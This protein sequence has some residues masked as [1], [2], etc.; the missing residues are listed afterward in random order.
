MELDLAKP[1]KQGFWIGDDDDRVFVVVLYERLPTFCY[2]CG[3]VGHGSNNCNRRSSGGSGHPSP[4]RSTDLASRQRQEVRDEPEARSEG[5]EAE[6][7]PRQSDILEETENL[8]ELSKTDYGPWMLVER[9]RGRGG[10]RGSAGGAGRPGS[11]AAHATSRDPGSRPSNVSIPNVSNVRSSAAGTTRGG[12]SGRGRGGAVS[13]RAQGS[14]AVIAEMTHSSDKAHIPMS[15]DSNLALVTPLKLGPEKSIP[16]DG[17]IASASKEAMAHVSSLSS[18]EPETPVMLPCP[19]SLELDKGKKVVVDK[20]LIPLT[21]PPI[22]RT[23]ADTGDG[24][25]PGG[26]PEAHQ[27]MVDKVSSVLMSSSGGSSGSE[28]DMSDSDDVEGG[29][30][31]GEELME[32]DDLMTLVQYQSSHR[33]EHLSRKIA[34]PQMTSHKKGR[35]GMEGEVS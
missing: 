34:Q 25:V 29:V 7:D 31:E 8:D 35:V 1:L 3:L 4:P 5:M 18:K 23:S 16:S 6:M 20:S 30:S 27:M 11:R 2:K 14:R 22:L 26:L 10:G 17:R 19:I 13:G 15:P 21:N 28:Q 12:S 9:R 32:T 33:K 24:L